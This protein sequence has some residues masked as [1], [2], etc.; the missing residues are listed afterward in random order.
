MGV[1]QSLKTFLRKNSTGT[2]LARRRLNLIEGS[3]VTITVADDS[4]NNEID[5]TI[6]STGGSGSP[7]GS[8]T[9]IQFN[10][11]GAFGGSS[12][13]TLNKTNGLITHSPS[14]ASISTGTNAIAH[15]I[16][17][18]SCTVTG[19][20]T[21][22]RTLSLGE[23]T[24]TASSSRTVTTAATLHIASPVAG[25]NVTINNRRTITSDTGAFL[26]SSGSWTNAS[27]KNKKENYEQVDHQETLRKL[28][29]L[30]VQKY[31]FIVEDDSIRRIGP[32]AQDFYTVFGL[33][34]DD[35]V[36]S[37]TDEIGVALSAIK[38]LLERVEELE[39]S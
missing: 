32:F 2:E 19:S 27:D 26:S 3:N 37:P 24:Y 5:V 31:N 23:T 12:I 8:D 15:N 11:G 30:P 20:V 25:S 4:E 38:G 7:G 10:D 6:A 28:K 35:T 13:L 22:A 14:G 21:N 29:E 17:A 18:N 33:G 36:I 16:A 34:D 9:E 1:F 39:K